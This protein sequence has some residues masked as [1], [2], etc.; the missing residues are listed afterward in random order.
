MELKF[1]WF[2]K[3]NNE[4]ITTEDISNG[5][6]GDYFYILQDEKIGLY[7]TEL[8]DNCLVSDEAMQFTGLTDKN[9]KDIYAGDLLKNETGRIGKVVWNPHA[10]CWDTNVVGKIKNTDSFGFSPRAWKYDLEVIGNIHQHSH[11]LDKGE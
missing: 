10:A 3:S 6:G 8:E 5:L 11:L 9:G 4:M 2:D 7:D 1:R